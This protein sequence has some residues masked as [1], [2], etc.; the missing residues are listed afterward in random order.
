MSETTTTPNETR[1]GLIKAIDVILIIEIVCCILYLIGSPIVTLFGLI[2]S[3]AD[4]S[5]FPILTALL[6]VAEMI[7]YLVLS[8]RARKELKN[9]RVSFIDSVFY[10]SFVGLAAWVVN[11]LIGLVSRVA[12]GRMSGVFIGSSIAGLIGQTIGTAIGLSLLILLFAKSKQLKAWF[13]LEGNTIRYSKFW[14][15][16]SK[17]PKMMTD[18]TMPEVVQPDPQT[19]PMQQQ[20]VTTETVTTTTTVVEQQIAESSQPVVTEV[21]FTETTHVQTEVNDTEVSST[22]VPPQQQ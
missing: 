6:V 13:G 19:Q 17:L 12:G 18:E 7:V 8:F 1:P 4:L 22:T 20:P 10:M 14:P 11:F 3:I 2:G 21:S 16:I 15:W 5:I 9:K